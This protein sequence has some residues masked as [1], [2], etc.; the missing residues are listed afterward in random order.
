MI[1]KMPVKTG[2]VVRSGRVVAEVSGRPVIV[3]PGGFPAYR[4]IGTGD[5]GPDVRQFQQ[6]LRARYGTPV[7]GKVDARTVADLRRLYKAIG[8]PAPTADR[9]EVPT[10]SAPVAPDLTPSGGQARPNEHLQIPMGEFFFVPQ[11]PATVSQ[12]PGKVGG[13]GTGPLVTLTGG[14]WQLR[15]HLD[16]AAERQVETL[17]KGVK[18]RLDD[19]HGAVVRLLGIRAGSREDQRSEPGPQDAESTPSPAADAQADPPTG[20]REAVFALDKEPVEAAFGQDRNI[21]IERGRSAPDAVVVPSSALWTAVDQ[22]IRV[23]SVG[24]DGATS[25][26]TVEVVLSVAGRV[27]VRPLTGTLPVGAQVIVAKRDGETPR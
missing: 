15:V 22:S 2:D 4:D 21:F 14:A 1:T 10:S 16:P 12:V 6:A 24:P 7:T 20:D 18:F 25:R 23:E 9:A 11:L 5:E 27:A 13:D 19:D 17:P 3:V 26:V 8:Y